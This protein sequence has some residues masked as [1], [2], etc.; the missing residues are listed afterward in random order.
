MT[1]N[2][3]GQFQTAVFAFV[4]LHMEVFIHRH[5]SE[6]VLPTLL[7]N[8]RLSAGRAPRGVLFVEALYAV[9]LVVGVN[10]VGYPVQSLGAH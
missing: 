6:R 10:R 3:G 4:A 1:L 5:H 7:R 8:Y 9:D 2:L